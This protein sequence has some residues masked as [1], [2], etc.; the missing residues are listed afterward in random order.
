ME[1]H[2]GAD[3]DRMQVHRDV[4]RSTARFLQADRPVGDRRCGPCYSRPCRDETNPRPTRGT[5]GA[6]LEAELTPRLTPGPCLG[7]TEVTSHNARPLISR[8]RYPRL[9]GRRRAISPVKVVIAAANAYRVRSG[10]HMRGPRGGGTAHPSVRQCAQSREARASSKSALKD[11]IPIFGC[12]SRVTRDH[13][14][15]AGMAD[16]RPMLEAVRIL[17]AD[18]PPCC[19]HPARGKPWATSGTRYLLGYGRPLAN[20]DHGR[21][22]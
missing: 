20:R 9:P 22:P 13:R 4:D 19:S 8:R 11:L 6:Q 17:H 14:L 21:L 1:R 12:R 15:V 18:I 16:R 2:V 5:R 7:R 10:T 3:P